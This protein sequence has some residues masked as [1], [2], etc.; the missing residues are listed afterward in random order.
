MTGYKTSEE[1]PYVGLEK[2]IGKTIT[3]IINPKWGEIECSDG[4]RFE[5]CLDE[6]DYHC[7]GL[8]VVTLPPKERIS[9]ITE[10]VEENRKC[11][12]CGVSEYRIIYMDDE[13]TEVK[14]Y[15][16]MYCHTHWDKDGKNL[17]KY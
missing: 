1:T 15:D 5:L 17:G 12:E 2:L 6:Y 7:L 4:S 8:D 14:Y 9:G 10:N 3:R 16:C 11:P 13:K